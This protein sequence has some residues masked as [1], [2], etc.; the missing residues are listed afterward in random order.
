MFGGAVEAALR[1]SMIHVGSP[2]FFGR[3]AKERPSFFLGE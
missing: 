1:P 3:R 2:S